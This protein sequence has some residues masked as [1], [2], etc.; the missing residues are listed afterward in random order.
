MTSIFTRAAQ[1]E[2]QAFKGKSRRASNRYA[3]RTPCRYRISDQELSSDWK[4]GETLDMSAG[5]ILITT[6]EAVP[7]TSELELEI[8]WLGLYHG[9][10]KVCLFVVGCVVRNDDR[11]MAV[12]ILRYEFG[13]VRP[14]VVSSR[15]TGKNLAAAY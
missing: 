9:K 8:E 12:R 5:G 7:V 4:S 11:G 10:P 6:H 14:A 15:R 13:V 3:V 2:S 1:Q